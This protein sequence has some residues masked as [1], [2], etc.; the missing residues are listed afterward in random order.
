MDADT[1]YLYRALLLRAAPGHLLEV[2]DLYQ[3]RK[4]VYD[5]V[6]D[7]APF[8]MR[9]RLGD[10]W[11]LLLIFPMRSF[12][13]YHSPEQRQRRQEAAAGWGVSDAE[14]QA[15]VAQ[16]VAWRE[17]VYVGGP[18]LEVTRAALAQGGLYHI[19]MFIAL[20]G[21]RG[22]LPRE[23]EMEHAYLAAAESH[24]HPGRRCGLGLVHRRRVPGL[25]ASC[26]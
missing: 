4:P 11:D 7:G 5:A 12:P 19:E 20:P 24:F 6:G 10:Q 8:I 13:V 1:S 3:S 17:E 21:K 15:L 14:F 18:P 23:R 22:E 16:R 9:H 25:Q 2:I 26:R